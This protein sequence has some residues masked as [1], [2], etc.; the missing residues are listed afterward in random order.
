LRAGRPFAA[1]PAPT[2]TPSL[3]SSPPSAIDRLAHVVARAPL[4]AALAV[5]PTLAVLAQ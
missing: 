3:T 4:K 5:F 1:Q 2:E